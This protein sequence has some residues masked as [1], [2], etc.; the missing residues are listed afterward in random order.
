VRSDAW[1]NVDGNRLLYAERFPSTERLDDATE[2]VV[3]Q[4][5]QP[6]GIASKSVSDAATL[7]AVSADGGQ[8]AKINTQGE[9]LL[10]APGRSGN[11]VASGALRQLPDATRMARVLW[12][13]RSNDLLYATA[14]QNNAV[15]LTLRAGNGS[16][17]T[18]GSVTSML[19]TCFSPDGAWLLVRTTERFLVW[20]VNAPGSTRYEWANADQSAIPY[21]S[22]DSTRLLVFDATGASLVDLGTKTTA[23]ALGYAQP[24]HARQGTSHWRPAPGSPWSPDG[25][26]AAFVGAA[27]DNWNGSQLAT[28]GLYVASVSASGPGKSRLVD[29]GANEAP[30][31]SYLDPSASF[32]LPS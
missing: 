29:S 10:G 16:T 30:L 23:R 19:D 3:S 7:P 13:P 31:W 17:R 28:A 25:A 22:P 5:D 18:L 24:Y 8:V 15:Q 1:W 4:A 21:W 26:S 14:A 11:T 32:L 12:R 2:Y 27:G 9:L 20:D 6:V